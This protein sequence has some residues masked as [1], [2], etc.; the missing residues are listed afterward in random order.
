MSK[1]YNDFQEIMEEHLISF[2]ENEQYLVSHHEKKR[3]FYSEVS[4][5]L[6]PPI[7][8]GFLQYVYENGMPLHDFINHVRSSQA[9]AINLLYPLLIQDKDTLI[10]L[11][12]KKS[13]IKIITGF[14]FE[15]SPSTNILGEWKSDENRPLEYVTAVDLKVDTKNE[16]NEDVTF[17]IEVK[18]TESEFTECGGYNSGKNTEEL[19]QAC[20]KSSIIWDEYK[21]CYLNGAKLTREYFSDSFNP[22]KS[23]RKEFFEN[24]CPFIS[25]HQCLRNH[26]LAKKLGKAFFVLV[27]H[28][29]NNFI[30]DKWKA[31]KSLL[32]DDS[33]LF[34]ISSGEIIDLTK[35]KNLKKYYNDRY[36]LSTSKH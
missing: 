25:N 12:S 33:D 34:E 31:Y 2:K 16:K 11:L 9:F 1:F 28:E 3:C 7:R 24:E 18:F 6:F 35:L 26:S 14:E 30:L 13:E 17:L 4:E 5:N 20:H 15:F 10:K 21:K 19:K 8:H 27:Y 23:F 32:L 29:N 36:W 22:Q